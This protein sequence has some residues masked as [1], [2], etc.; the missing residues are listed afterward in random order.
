MQAIDELR[1]QMP[2][3]VPCVVDGVKLQT[4][5]RARQVIPYEHSTILAEYHMADKDTVDA[6]IRGA[7]HAKKD[8][9]AT[10]FYD[11]AAI[12]LK[13]ADL[14]STKYRYRLM[15]ATMLGQSKNVWQAEIDAATELPDFFR[16]NV[17]YADEI[18]KTQ[19]PKNADGIWNR[20]EWRALEGF[21]AAV[22]PFNFTA[23]GGNL[24]GAPVMMGNVCVWKP[25][26]TAILSGYVIMQVFEEAGLPPGV[27]QFV[28]GPAQSI[29]SQLIN[30]K[31]FAG[32]HFT[33]S[34]GIFRQ[35]YQDIAGNLEKYRNFPRIGAL[36]PKK[37]TNL[38]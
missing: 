11:R 6:A 38:Q 34:S 7:L 9:E 35:L 10:P 36:L 21:V 17:K 24:V 30:H 15:A 25:S 22:S 16:F 3:I 12:F 33:G 32:L 18:Y 31:D 26:D 23:I 19:P 37:E 8:W 5:L 29:V 14:I 28:P 4:N 13:A 20:L 1:S 27:I 2:V